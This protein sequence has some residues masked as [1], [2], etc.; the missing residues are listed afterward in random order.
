MVMPAALNAAGWGLYLRGQMTGHIHSNPVPWLMSLGMVMASGISM[1]AHTGD[2]SAGLMYFV[3]AIPC[4][5]VFALSMKRG[6]HATHVDKLLLT[7]AAVVLALSLLATQSAIIITVGYYL[8][9]YALFALKIHKGS[10]VESLTPWLA[11]IA[12]AAAQL[13]LIGTLDEPSP[14]DY[15]IPAT[16]FICWGFIAGVIIFANQKKRNQSGPI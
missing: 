5:L 4:A 10:A 2:M 12:A 14:L 13:V 11:W 1:T 6:F 7:G 15:I 3:G 9:T 16:N 8:V